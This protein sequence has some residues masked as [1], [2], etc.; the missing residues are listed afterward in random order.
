MEELIKELLCTTLESV[1]LVTFKEVFELEEISTELDELDCANDEMLDVRIWLDDWSKPELDSLVDVACPAE[2][3][4]TLLAELLALTE[5]LEVPLDEEE[6]S[7]AD[8]DVPVQ[9]PKE[10]WQPL[11]QN[12]LPVPLNELTSDTF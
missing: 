4:L 2:L 7:L 11:P 9:V 10:L 3:E 8:D 1:N 6:L 5:E 12:A